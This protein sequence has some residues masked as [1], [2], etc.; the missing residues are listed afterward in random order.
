[1][2]YTNEST[3]WLVAIVLHFLVTQVLPLSLAFV[4][5]FVF[6]KYVKPIKINR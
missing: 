3:F 5:G 2:Q 6:G 1:M 4:A